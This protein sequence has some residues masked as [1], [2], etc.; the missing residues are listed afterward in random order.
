[1][2]WPQDADGDVFRRLAEDGFDF[3]QEVDIDFNIDFDS[4]PLSE[5][6]T[7]FLKKNYPDGVVIHPDEDDFA[8]GIDKGYFCFV[9]R[10]KLTYDFVVEMQEKVTRDVAPFGGRCNAWGILGV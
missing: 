10:G 8:E 5:E 6:A 1:M 4:W 9:V 2:N 7:A 3:T